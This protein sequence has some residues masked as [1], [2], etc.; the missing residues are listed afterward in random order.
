MSTEQLEPWQIRQRMFVRSIRIKCAERD[1][2]DFDFGRE[3]G[4]G[5]NNWAQMRLLKKPM[6]LEEMVKAAQAVGCT[7]SLH[8][9]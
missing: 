1:M 5:P 8:I 7:L 6:K 4:I 9:S 2:T 3:S